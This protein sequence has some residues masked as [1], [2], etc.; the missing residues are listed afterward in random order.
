MKVLICMVAAIALAAPASAGDKDKDKA[1][2]KAAAALALAKAADMD[3]KPVASGPPVLT[4]LDKAKERASAQAKPLVLWVDAKPTEE[5][6][7]AVDVIHCAIKEFPES[8]DAKCIV[9]TCRAGKC[10]RKASVNTVPSASLLKEM[11]DD[12]KKEPAPKGGIAAEPEFFISTSVNEEIDG[13]TLPP[14]EPVKVVKYETRYVLQCV[15]G[16][17]RMVLVNVPVQDS[18]KA[19]QVVKAPV[20]SSD[21]PCVAATGSCPCRSQAV[22]SSGRFAQWRESRPRLFTGGFLRAIFGRFR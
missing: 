2:A 9:F 5:T 12:A 13:E 14:P 18:P 7:K 6:L 16:Q 1:K 15:N 11:V 4:D 21:C 22:G 10:D 8:K 20:A 19:T 3:K 17:C